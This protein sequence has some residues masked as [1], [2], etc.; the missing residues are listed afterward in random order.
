M[1]RTKGGVVGVF[2]EGGDLDLD[3]DLD[4]ALDLDRFRLWFSGK[5]K[6][7]SVGLMFKSRLW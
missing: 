1:G 4:L 3:L 2:S 5:G 6:L 7:R